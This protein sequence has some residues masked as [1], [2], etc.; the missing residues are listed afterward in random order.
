[1]IAIID[2]DTGNLRSVCNAL[3]RIGAEY[4][5]TD[6]P[7]VIAKADRVLL[8]GVGEASSAM[9]KLQE[10]GLCDVIKS[11]D[12]PVLGICI[13]MQLMCRHSE[14][15]D[16]DCLGIFDS[17]VRKF[18][19]S[20]DQGVKVPHMGW[21]TLSRLRSPLFKDM[22]D[23]DFVY[24]V[25][26]FAADVCDDSIAVSENGRDFSAALH[27]DNFYGV[28]FHPEKSGEAGEKILRNFMN[29]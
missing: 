21:N 22:S 16:V 6:R 20:P 11:L 2:Y 14:E 8:P 29:L 1:M 5:L 19:P 7:D 27:K 26:S 4:C 18:N 13:G 15:G 24:F 10:R 12:V 3:D 17:R 23:G 28:Q 9:L 25:H